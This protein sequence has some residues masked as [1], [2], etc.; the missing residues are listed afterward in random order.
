M[1]RLEADNE[2]LFCRTL[3]RY[4]SYHIVDFVPFNM[5][6]NNPALLAKRTLFELPGGLVDYMR[7]RGI[8]PNATHEVDR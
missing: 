2:A 4:A 5:Y 7:I 6:K 8:V 3:N 1:D